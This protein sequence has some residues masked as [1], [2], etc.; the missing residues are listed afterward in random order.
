MT[1]HV[2]LSDGRSLSIRLKGEPAWLTP[3][4][5]GKIAVTT[6]PAEPPRITSLS[7]LWSEMAA[8]PGD[9]VVDLTNADDGYTDDELLAAFQEVRTGAAPPPDADAPEDDVSLSDTA[10]E[11]DPAADLSDDEVYE[12]WRSHAEQQGFDL[13]EEDATP[14]LEIG[15]SVEWGSGL[16]TAHGILQELDSGMGQALVHVAEVVTAGGAGEQ[17]S[18]TGKT[19]KVDAGELRPSKLRPV[20]TEPIGPELSADLADDPDAGMDDETF[21]QKV[22]RGMGLDG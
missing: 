15:Q 9:G 1:E 11:G 18:P 4:P 22:R 12:V 19:I 14:A 2:D 8:H 16:G 10:D 13:A 5:G 7:D 20:G 6:H 3:M 17:L 21:W